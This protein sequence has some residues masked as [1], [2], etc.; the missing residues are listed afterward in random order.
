MEGIREEE[1]GFLRKI[2]AYDAAITFG[3]VMSPTLIFLAS[4]ITYSLILGNDL[5]V[6]GPDR[7]GW[8]AWCGWMGWRG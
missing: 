7:R 1:L 3:G 5:S 2:V 4:I 6:S 8:V